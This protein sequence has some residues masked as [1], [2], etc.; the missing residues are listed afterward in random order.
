MG[1]VARDQTETETAQHSAQ[2]AVQPLSVPVIHHVPNMC[3]REEGL[4]AFSRLG[5][6]RAS[7]GWSALAGTVPIP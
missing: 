1:S 6:P 7:V 5:R 4:K 2:L 3:Q